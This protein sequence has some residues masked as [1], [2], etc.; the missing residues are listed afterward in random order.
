MYYDWL[1]CFFSYFGATMCK[2]KW[3][4]VGVHVSAF[5]V[6]PQMFFNTLEVNEVPVTLLMVVGYI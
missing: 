5:I 3:E 6:Q 1:S 4:E 2:G